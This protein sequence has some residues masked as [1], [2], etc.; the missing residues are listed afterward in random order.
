MICSF[1]LIFGYLECK[2]FTS[3]PGYCSICNAC[4]LEYQKWLVG[5]VEVRDRTTNVIYYAVAV[6]PV[7]ESVQAAMQAIM[8][9]RRLPMSFNILR[10]KTSLETRIVYYKYLDKHSKR[11][12]LSWRIACVLYLHLEG[13]HR[14]LDVPVMNVHLDMHIIEDFWD[15]LREMLAEKGLELLVVDGKTRQDLPVKEQWFKTCGKIV[16]EKVKWSD[17]N[18]RNKFDNTP[19]TY[20]IYNW[21]TNHI[22]IGHI[23]SRGGSLDGRKHS[24]IHFESFLDPTKAKDVPNDE[25][26]KAY[27]LLESP[28]PGISGAYQC[29]AIALL[30]YHCA[31]HFCGSFSPKLKITNMYTPSMNFRSSQFIPELQRFMVE[32]CKGKTIDIKATA[33]TPATDS[34][35][36]IVK[37]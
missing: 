12:A 27:H 23:Q 5:I 33:N 2:T 25:H 11:E 13:Y 36:W 9:Q 24:L 30:G 10:S 37:I 29:D 22:Y 1:S 3:V 17:E 21:E 26:R 32:H 16:R 34:D 20:A 35:K 6:V 19:I 8:T 18:H 15:H 4:L 14:G 31:N 7:I 28:T